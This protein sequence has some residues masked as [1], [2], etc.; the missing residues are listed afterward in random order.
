ME[1]SWVEERGLHGQSAVEVEVEEWNCL[2]CPLYNKINK[3]DSKLKKINNQHLTKN[4]YSALTTHQT[5][6]FKWSICRWTDKKKPLLIV[7]SE[8]VSHISRSHCLVLASQLSFRMSWRCMTEKEVRV[9]IK[10]AL[11]KCHLRPS[12]MMTFKHLFLAFRK[13]ENNL[14]TGIKNKTPFKS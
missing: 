4:W 12:D 13:S 8:T 6:T 14:Q 9:L 11:S 3:I 7:D 2:L 5:Q 10:Q 1:E